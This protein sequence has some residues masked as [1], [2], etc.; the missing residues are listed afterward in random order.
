MLIYISLFFAAN[1]DQMKIWSQSDYNITISESI[2]PKAFQFMKDS[3]RNGSVLIS[4]RWESIADQIHHFLFGASIAYALD[5][6]IVVEMKKYPLEMQQ[7]T[8]KLPLIGVGT[9]VSPNSNFTRVNVVR[10]FQ[11]KNWEQIVGSDPSNVLIVRN[12]DPITSVYSNHVLSAILKEKFET[13]APF[14]ILRHHLKPSIPK[15][16][17]YL[18][19]D[20]QYFNTRRMKSMSNITHIINLFGNLIKKSSY[21]RI[22]I[23][24]NNQH[25]Q[26]TLKNTFPDAE[27]LSESEESFWKLVG[28]SS[29]IGT[30]RSKFSMAVSYARGVPNTLVD[31]LT[32]NIFLQ[33][34][35]LSGVL[36]PYVQDIEDLDW[37]TNEK[38]RICDNNIDDLRDILN[39]YVL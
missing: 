4:M 7:P 10:E 6:S 32:S 17:P 30:Y 28:A 35:Y 9:K 13:H 14:F 31:T 38:L 26:A 21:N 22:I 5:R 29:F 24:T 15:S 12:Y 3:K 2:F 34:S 18:A 25:M 36:S 37:T 33:S 20:C 27:V 23:S 39:D 19:I 11:C 1:S 16:D 8:L